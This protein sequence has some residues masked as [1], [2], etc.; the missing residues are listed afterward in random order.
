MHMLEYVVATLLLEQINAQ[1]A[2][3]CPIAE[4]L[5]ARCKYG[6]ANVGEANEKH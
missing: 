6:C 3:K 2:Q 1:I 5:A 4:N